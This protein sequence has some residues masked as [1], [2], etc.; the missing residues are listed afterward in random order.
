MQAVLN[1]QETHGDL[2]ERTHENVRRI[3]EIDNEM[4]KNMALMHQSQE[5]ML[6]AQDEMM[7]T[8]ITFCAKLS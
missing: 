7:K 8:L 3:S 4:A 5:R 1:I 6:H 2:S